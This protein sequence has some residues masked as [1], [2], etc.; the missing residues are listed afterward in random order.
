LAPPILPEVLLGTFRG[1]ITLMSLPIP[2][3]SLKIYPLP[4]FLLSAMQSLTLKDF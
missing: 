3:K 1:S 4:D 2:S